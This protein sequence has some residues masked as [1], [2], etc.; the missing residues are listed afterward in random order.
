[1]DESQPITSRGKKA[2]VWLDQQHIKKTEHANEYQILDWNNTSPKFSSMSCGVPTVILV[3]E[4][5]DQ[6]FLCVTL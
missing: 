4:F 5:T 1:M 3:T 2:E 6:L